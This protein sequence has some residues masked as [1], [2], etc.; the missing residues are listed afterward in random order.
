MFDR[1]N[2]PNDAKALRLARSLD[3]SLKNDAK[4][5]VRFRA[6]ASVPSFELWLLLHYQDIQAPLHRRE[7][8]HRLKQHLQDDEK[9]APHAFSKTR[10]HLDIALTRAA[11]LAAKFSAEDELQPYTAVHELV[12][13]LT[14][15][16]T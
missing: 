1:D 14:N 10:E 8:M 3:C 9:G 5:L 15:L 2:H 6:I 11:A 7:V 12:S 16:R 4:Q 13:L